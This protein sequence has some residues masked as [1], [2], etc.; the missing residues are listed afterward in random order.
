MA[1]PIATAT[2]SDILILIILTII[3]L[4]KISKTI[5]HAE[6]VK[7]KP[8]VLFWII[9]KYG[10]V[11]LQDG[12]G[13]AAGQFRQQQAVFV[14]QLAQR[15]GNGECPLP[16]RNVLLFIPLRIDFFIL[17]KMLVGDSIKIALFQC[18]PFIYS[19]THALSWQ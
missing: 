12:C 8:L 15:L 9:Q 4:L 3:G 10:L 16:A 6:M 13:R 7:V 19:A 17:L 1:A 2:P 5:I 14:K 18:S 11:Q